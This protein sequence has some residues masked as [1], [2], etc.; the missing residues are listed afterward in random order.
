MIT[1]FVKYNVTKVFADMHSFTN[2]K[3]YLGKCSPK[4]RDF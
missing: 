2:I 1:P 3:Q 4:N